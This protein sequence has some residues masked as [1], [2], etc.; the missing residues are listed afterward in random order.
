MRRRC[1]ALTTMYR[2]LCQDTSIQFDR[3]CLKMKLALT[4]RRRKYYARLLASL[5]DHRDEAENDFS[6]D[7]VNPYQ[8]IRNA[9]E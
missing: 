1:T 3:S 7:E 9:G 4:R 8:W 2:K 5:Q 6:N